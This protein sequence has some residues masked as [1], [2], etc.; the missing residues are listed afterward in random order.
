MAQTQEKGRKI[1]LTGGH[2]GTTAIAVVEE[3]FRRKDKKMF[4]DIF[5]IG[6]KSAFE[7]KKVKSIESESFEVLGIKSHTIISG[8]LQTKFT[9]YTIPSIAKIPLGFLHAFYLLFKIK[10]DIILSFGGFS[11]FPV[12]TIGKLFGIPIVIHDQTAAAG[13]SNRWGAIFADRIAISREQSRNY[14]NNKKVV[15]TGNPIMTQIAEIGAPEKIGN[16]PTLFVLGGSRGSITINNNVKSILDDL[17]KEY[18]VIHQVGEL[19]YNEFDSIK[20]S[21]P[22]KLSNNYYIYSRIDPMMIDNVYHQSDIIVGRSGANTVSEIIAI[23]RPSIFIP[24]PYTYL[25]EQTKN[26]KV[27]VDIGLSKIIDQENLTPE[28]LLKEIK[29][30]AQDWQSIVKKTSDTTSPDIGA[31]SRLVDLLEEVV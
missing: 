23:K 10:P 21:L 22:K 26:A 31:S 25:D 29:L 6:P 28:L 12:I 1:L 27:A 15:L 11:A 14:F 2:A 20:K 3:L 24:L 30:T 17:L 9:R 8:K 19:A 5:W 18:T 13:R 7:G 4:S 16:P